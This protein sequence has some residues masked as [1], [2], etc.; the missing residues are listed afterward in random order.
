MMW[1]AAAVSAEMSTRVQNRLPLQEADRVLSKLEEHLIMA[2]T[3]NAGLY[4]EELE[5][6]ELSVEQC[7]AVLLDD[8]AWRSKVPRCSD[9]FQSTSRLLPDKIKDHVTMSNVKSALQEA[10]I[11]SDAHLETAPVSSST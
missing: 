6:L 10:G 9:Q 8:E 4:H 7:D 5:E 11:R 1:R 2:E 3:I